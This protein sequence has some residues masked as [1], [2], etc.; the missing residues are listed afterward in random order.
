MIKERIKIDQR[1]IRL[2][3]NCTKMR[4]RVQTISNLFRVS[5]ANKFLKEARKASKTQNP[6]PLANNRN[7]SNLNPKHQFHKTNKTH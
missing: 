6:I 5:K 2:G 3:Q 4:F 7:Q 1:M